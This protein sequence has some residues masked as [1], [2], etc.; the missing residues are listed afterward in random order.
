MREIISRSNRE[1]ERERERW[2][3]VETGVSSTGRCLQVLD[4]GEGVLDKVHLDTIPH[5]DILT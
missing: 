3:E 5:T 4:R 1:R 2:G